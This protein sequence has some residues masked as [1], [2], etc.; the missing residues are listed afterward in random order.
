MI[1]KKDSFFQKNR[2]IL[3][4]FGTT[5]CANQIDAAVGSSLRLRNR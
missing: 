2:R 5:M 3:D 4:S 1:K